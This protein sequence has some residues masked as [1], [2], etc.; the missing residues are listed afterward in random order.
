MGVYGTVSSSEIRFYFYDPDTAVSRIGPKWST[1]NYNGM[2]GPIRNTIE[3]N[4]E[5]TE[6]ERIKNA[7]SKP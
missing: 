7:E 1:C 5:A 3:L 2:I 6:A 4:V